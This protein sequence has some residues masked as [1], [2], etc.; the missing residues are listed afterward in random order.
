MWPRG[1]ALVQKCNAAGC[2][3]SHVLWLCGPE[4]RGRFSVMGHFTPERG[5]GPRSGDGLT[6]RALVLGV[7]LLVAFGTFVVQPAS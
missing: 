3:R 7:L 4:N 2:P 5:V 6:G 1:Y